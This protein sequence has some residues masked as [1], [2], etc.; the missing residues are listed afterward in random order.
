MPR[1]VETKID[2]WWSAPDHQSK[3]ASAC[4]ERQVTTGSWFLQGRPFEEWKGRENSFLWLHGIPGAGKTVLCS[5]IIEEIACHCKSDSSLAIAYFYF[6]FHKGTLP[7]AAVKSLIKQLS[8]KSAIA[9]N[10]LRQ[11]FSDSNEGR[12]HPT[13]Q[14]LM[15]ALKDITGSFQHVYIVLDALDE[16]PER[17]ELLTLLRDIMDWGLGTLHLLA[18]SRRESDIEDMLD[19]VTSHQV[20]LDE[21]LVDD[22][23]RVHVSKTLD[24]DIK[25]SRCS[26]EE[27]KIIESTLADGAH[28]M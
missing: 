22:D 26:T 14:E 9:P 19:S 11:L 27:K 18:A 6:D 7:M 5:T 8:E 13:R 24:L 25:F 21:S 10:I 23:I 28:G 20:Y 12:R 16:C 17:D 3:H 4:K 1:V 2:K 15:A